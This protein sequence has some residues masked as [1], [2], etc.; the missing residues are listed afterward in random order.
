MICPECLEDKTIITRSDK[1]MPIN[2]ILRRR[3]CKSCGHLWST[4]EMELDPL[5]VDAVY[6]VCELAAKLAKAKEVASGGAEH[7]AG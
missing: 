2:A 1:G 6:A 5:T 3:Q 4:L 7:F